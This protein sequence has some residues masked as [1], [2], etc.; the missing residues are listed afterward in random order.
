MEEITIYDAIG[1]EE[2]TKTDRILQY[3]Q[4]EKGSQIDHIHFTSFQELD[5]LQDY[6]TPPN[7]TLPEI[8]IKNLSNFI[9]LIE[10]ESKYAVSVQF[11]KNMQLGDS[12]LSKNTMVSVKGIV[13]KP[14]PVISNLL[15]DM[16]DVQHRV[17]N[18]S[19]SQYT[20][21][22]TQ[23]LFFQDLSHPL[24]YQTTYMFDEHIIKTLTG[25][26]DRLDQ[27]RQ[28][29]SNMWFM[30]HMQV[31]KFPPIVPCSKSNAQPM[32]DV[33]DEWKLYQYEKVLGKSSK[34]ATYEAERIRA[35][36]DQEKRNRAKR[37]SD[38]KKKI[39]AMKKK[40]IAKSKFGRTK[41][42]A[43][44]QEV[45]D[46]A[47]KSSEKYKKIA[48]DNDCRHI[49]LL[50]KMMRK[51]N[52][53]IWRQLKKL[54]PLR[55]DGMLNCTNCDLPAL[56]P[57]HYVQ[58]NG[59]S[60][61]DL[62]QFANAG[63]KDAYFC[64]I[65]GEKIIELFNEQHAS[66]IK[67]K[68]VRQEREKDDLGLK[69]WKETKS[70]TSQ[71]V[72]FHVATDEN[73]LI[74]TIIDVIR[75]FIETHIRA[76]EKRKEQPDVISHMEYLYIGI[77][78]FAFYTKLMY[79]HDTVSF[80]FVQGGKTMKKLQALLTA[81]LGK[82]IATRMLTISAIPSISTAS[83]KPIF[84]SAFQDI[85]NNYDDQGT[86][87]N[88]LPPEF[89]I[90]DPTYAYIFYAKQK[91][92]P[93]LEISDVKSVLDA[94]LDQL[95]KM[96]NM[97]SALVIPKKWNEKGLYAQY[98]YDSF[99][100]F[101]N[102]VKE[103]TFLIPVFKNVKHA[104]HTEQYN[105]LRAVETKLLDAMRIAA[106]IPTCSPIRQQF[107][108]FEFRKVGLSFIYCADGRK[109]KFDIHVFESGIT[110]VEISK[111]NVDEWMLDPKKNARF[112]KM[113]LVDMRCS[114]CGTYLKSNKQ[115]DKSIIDKLDKIDKLKSFYEQ[116]IFKCPVEG[117]HDFLDEKCKK[118]GVTK[119]ML[120]N[121]DMKYFEKH[122]SKIKNS[123]PKMDIPAQKK[124]TRKYTTWTKQ[125]VDKMAKILGIPG[126]FLENIGS[127][128][129]HKFEDAYNG[130][131]PRCSLNRQLQLQTHMS[132]LLVKYEQ[133]R[134][135]SIG[136]RFEKWNID[137]STFPNIAENYLEKRHTIKKNI[138]NFIA[139]SIVSSLVK[140]KTFSKNKQVSQAA[141]D[142]VDYFISIVL[143]SEKMMS[144]PGILHAEFYVEKEYHTERV[145]EVDFEEDFNPFSLESSGIDAEEM[146]NNIGTADD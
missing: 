18:G 26:V 127:I 69:L 85:V 132:T 145:E 118:C 19:Y 133:L 49:I 122:A 34:K 62:M 113:K 131:L 119:K 107:G 95:E 96:D 86:F 129:S 124:F 134:N 141:S 142:F 128:E 102:Y 57:H 51:G 30:N 4:L 15:V 59:G 25:L 42:T 47:Y 88:M 68:L 76:A 106:R 140:I 24:H 21:S 70:I 32:F 146:E 137:F 67:G 43:K 28:V 73:A 61:D 143:K 123:V 130:V 46:L 87:N 93:S 12:I 50:K 8:L 101:I 112:L 103:K 9:T 108:K 99:I 114:V 44:E 120:R 6:L 58:F 53:G 91:T 98:A 2:I 41:L 135:G 29:Y 66:F 22:N 126:V 74:N 60:R 10:G 56:C 33:M 105:K 11:N 117:R 139:Y 75:P 20:S 144:D 27:I 125:P 109:H 48:Q 90:G 55:G 40:H 84:A 138:S 79:D 52:P 13:L 37:I 14:M 92:N 89:A 82:I 116:F 54:V 45:V 63:S 1:V 3:A 104:E 80:T 38:E 72:T 83:I 71:H 94:G 111:K 121:K 17:D 5:E 77:Y 81:A 36:Q 16:V 35:A 39:I 97:T 100:H 31:S 115:S 65:C 136:D 23:S 78:V 64:K 7:T 110:D